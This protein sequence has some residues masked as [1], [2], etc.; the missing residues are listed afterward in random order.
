MLI[1]RVDDDN[2]PDQITEL[3]HIDLLPADLSQLKP[4]TSLD[5]LEAQT[6]AI[7]QEVRRKLLVEQWKEIDQAAGGRLPEVFSPWGALGAM[8]TTPSRWPLDWAL[9]ICPAGS[10]TMPP[11]RGIPCPATPSCPPMAG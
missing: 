3:Q 5:E 4:E 11:E 10:A 1:C 7:G 9:S 8:A 2:N 6:F